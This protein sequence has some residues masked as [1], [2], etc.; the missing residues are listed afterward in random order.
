MTRST[1]FMIG[2]ALLAGVAD[3]LHVPVSPTLA[4]KK[5]TITVE[6]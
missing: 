5:I 6:K 2:A 3:Y 4:S 1:V